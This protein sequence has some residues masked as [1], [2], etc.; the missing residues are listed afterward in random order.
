MKPLQRLHRLAADISK[1]MVWC[2]AGGRILTGPFAGMSYPKDS[3]GSSYKAKLLGTYE[4]E[5]HELIVR[6]SKNPPGLVLNIGAAEGYY[7]V[8][9]ARLWKCPVVTYEIDPTGRELLTKNAL[10]NQLESQIEVCELASPDILQNR[11]EIALGTECCIVCDIEGGEDKL[12]DPKAIPA[13]A[14]TRLLIE[15]H[16]MDA[17]GVGDRLRQRFNSTHAIQEIPTQTRVL[18][19]FP[20]NWIG[21]WFIPPTL[22]LRFMDERRLAPM[23]WLIL[24]PLK[25]PSPRE[26]A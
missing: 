9:L 5:L 22:K 16:E 10:L 4:M 19:D 8:G 1:R 13:L 17:P 14:R 18:K 3:V 7:A 26:R 2:A 21:R 6:W 25:Q 20:D 11:I 12:L 24:T 15:V 23:S